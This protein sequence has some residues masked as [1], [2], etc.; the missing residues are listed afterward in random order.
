[1]VGGGNPPKPPGHQEAG[2]CL[3]TGGDGLGRVEMGGW[4]G[5][6]EDHLHQVTVDQQQVKAGGKEQVNIEQVEVVQADV[7]GE[8]LG[9]GQGQAQD[10]Q[11]LGVERGHGRLEGV[12]A[13]Q[14]A[15]DAPEA[16]AVEADGGGGVGGVEHL[17]GGGRE[18]QAVV[19]RGDGELGG[20]GEEVA[21]GGR[22]RWAGQAGVHWP[23]GAG[24]GGSTLSS[25]T[26]SSEEA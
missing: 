3:G 26:I 20:E 2:P 4:V 10:D 5:T 19:L 25:G 7:V 17:Q 16:G 21:P 11:Q 23:H 22:E 1:M 15:G 24:R 9:E 12:A 8:D 14:E 6:G 13:G 18:G